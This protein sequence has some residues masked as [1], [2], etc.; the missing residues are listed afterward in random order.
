MKILLLN[1]S[2]RINGNTKTAL[3]QIIQG[4]QSNVK[5]AEIELLDVTKL[6]LSGCANCNNCKENG[7]I[8]I[9][10]DDSNMVVQ[11]IYDSDVVVLGTPVYYWG[12]NAQLKMVIDKLYCKD[13]QLRRQKK[14][15]GMVTIGEADVDDP[16]Y[17][18]I[19]SQVE[20]ICNYMGW[21]F[22]FSKSVSA[23]EEGDLAKD[24]IQLQE[25]YDLWAS[26]V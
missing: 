17:R 10:P 21:N 14:K 4:I 23:F 26:V 1:A 24:R 15:L 19:F 12:M 7:G 2:P 20:Y 13:D 25:I 9:I 11:K 3:N 22:I 6:K 16:Q 5:D 8:C 18:L